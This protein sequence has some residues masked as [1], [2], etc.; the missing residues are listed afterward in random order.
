MQTVAGDL[1]T[2]AERGRIQGYLASVWGIS[3]VIAP[4]LG[5]LFA[6]YLS[7]RWIFLVNIPIG[8]FALYLILRD[9]HDDVERRRTASTTWAPCWS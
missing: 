4:A 3:A 1:Y 2:V 5:G 8:V 7:W 9:L 6:Q